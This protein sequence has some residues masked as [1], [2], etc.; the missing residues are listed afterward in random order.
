MTPLAR[1][2]RR[3]LRKLNG[4]PSRKLLM[5]AV[6]PRRLN[7][8]RSCFPGAF[9]VVP[10]PP[11]PV[12][13]GGWGTDD[14]PHLPPKCPWQNLPPQPRKP[15]QQT[16][17]VAGAGQGCAPGLPRPGAPPIGTHAAPLPVGLTGGGSHS[18][19]RGASWRYYFYSVIFFGTEGLQGQGV[20]RL[21]PIV[22][23]ASLP[24]S[25]GRQ[26][27]GWCT[28]ERQPANAV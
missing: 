27:D 11:P 8:G 2:G 20:N 6:A 22:V 4:V 19:R 9:L 17:G 18:G 23:L 25:L 10:A 1:G 12:L 14:T 24:G 16:A 13:L 26:I 7:C 28:S 5:S 21:N 15:G 3:E